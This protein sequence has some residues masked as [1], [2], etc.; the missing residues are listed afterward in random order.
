MGIRYIDSIYGK[1]FNPYLR[2]SA[3]SVAIES[4]DPKSYMAY[5]ECQRWTNS[6]KS[7]QLPSI[8]VVLNGLLDADVR[9]GKLYELIKI[10]L[11]A[12][13]EI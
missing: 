7:I 13:D 9:F 1:E 12:T 4:E 6:T 11:N 8:S 10:K 5:L 3:V 2:I